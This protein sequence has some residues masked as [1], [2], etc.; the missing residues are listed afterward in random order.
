M[1][2]IDNNSEANYKEFNFQLHNTN[3]YGQL[4]QP[5]K[6]EAV[7]LAVHG[8]G[9]HSGRYGGHFAKAFNDKN[10]AVVSY[11]QFG[12]GKTEGKR[13]HTPSYDANLDCIYKMLAEI[14]GYYGDEISV[15]LYGHS[16]G[17]NLVA[18]YVLRRQSSIKGAIISSPMLRL[19]FDPP[20]WKMK[21]GGWLRNIYP[22]F[23]EKT[24]IELAAITRDKAEQEK[25]VTDPLIHDKVTINYT[26]PFFD[27]G[28]WAIR[29]AGI[30]N[31]KVFIFH[32]TGDRITDHNASK[33]YALTA[34]G[35][36][37]LK[38]YEGGYHELHNDICKEDVL[39]D[40]TNWIES[41][42]TTT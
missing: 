23:T 41:F 24:G 22:T 2:F 33:E 15:F 6:I 17:G 40:M 27:A 20:A 42:Y 32:G 36:A 10:I 21:V 25:Y 5:E 18:N 38:L 35:N 28:E 13:G 39:K 26:L 19:A 31:K 30:L 4:F 7:L 14:Q 8:M 34:D 12:H 3:F 1:K 9:E 11:D 29:N 37:T 16:M